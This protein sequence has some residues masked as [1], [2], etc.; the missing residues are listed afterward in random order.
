MK[1]ALGLII[2]L[3]IFGLILL[4]GLPAADTSRGSPEEQGASGG[5]DTTVPPSQG[6]EAGG[7][8]DPGKGKVKGKDKGKDKGKG[9]VKA[10]P[11]RKEFSFKLDLGTDFS[12]H[13]ALP[14]ILDPEGRFIRDEDVRFHADFRAYRRIRLD[15]GNLYLGYR[16]FERVNVEFNELNLQSH[17]ASVNHIWKV[18][19]R[20]RVTTGLDYR[21]FLLDK[22]SLLNRYRLS[23]QLFFHEKGPW[24]GK[25]GYE[26]AIRNYN[27]NDDQDAHAHRASVAQVRYLANGRDYVSFGYDYT[28]SEADGSRFSYDRHRLVVSLTKYLKQH[29]KLT[30]GLSETFARYDGIDLIEGER[31]RDDR[32]GVFL[33]Y[34]RKVNDTT[35]VYG[36]ASWMEQNSNLGRQDYDQAIFFLGTTM[37][38]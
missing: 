16:F 14:R 17:T 31:R 26:E 18:N 28:R 6:D 38:F 22:S 1:K 8:A 9:K 23:G 19:G 2:F 33:R 27:S 3:L 24:W 5:I 10:K 20:L 30:G 35:S 37:R 25:I 36:G 21:H 4:P 34:E 12:T 32:F 13:L 11:A 15:K 7:G 29:G